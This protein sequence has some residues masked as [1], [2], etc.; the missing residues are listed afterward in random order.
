MK[1]IARI[2]LVLAFGFLSGCNPS[3]NP[4]MTGT[5][6][7]VLTPTGSASEVIQATADLT[8]LGNQVIGQ[9]S[10]SENAAAC[11]TTASMTGT[12]K[13]NTLTLQLAQLQSAIDFTGTA[14]LAFTSASGTYTATAGSC[15]Q[16]GGSG[17]WSASLD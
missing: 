4:A 11:G 3:P 17:S 6:L 14:N 2:A 10:L 12:V 13:G 5:W 7:F 8:Q 15:L 1:N 9:V 16:N